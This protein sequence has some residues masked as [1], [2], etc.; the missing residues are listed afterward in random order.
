VTVARDTHAG[1]LGGRRWPAQA[2]GDHEACAAQGEGWRDTVGVAEQRRHGEF[3][4][5]SDE[6]RQNPTPESGT[7]PWR[8]EGEGEGAPGRLDPRGGRESG[9]GRRTTAFCTEVEGNGGGV[10]ARPR[11]R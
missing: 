4:A 7:R 8:S 9:K 3:S 5:N 10:R 2:R 11:G 6:G 1:G